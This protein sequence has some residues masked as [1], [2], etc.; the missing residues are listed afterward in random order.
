M[1]NNKLIGFTLIMLLIVVYYSYFSP[2]QAPIIEDEITETEKITNEK[3]TISN[4]TNEILN[5]NYSS[6]NNNKEETITIENENLVIDFNS[7]GAKILNVFLKKFKNTEGNQVK[8]YGHKE[9]NINYQLTSKN[10][11]DLDK[12]IFKHSTRKSD[13][14]IRITFKAISNDS[15]TIT[16]SYLLKNNSYLVENDISYNDNSSSNKTLKINWLNKI[17]HQEK[18]I[19]NEKLQ[20]TINY[21]Y[22]SEDFD[23]LSASS[24]ENQNISV[25]ESLLWITSKQQFFTSGIIN[26]TGF[27]NSDL[28]SIYLEDSSFVKSLNI[29]TEIS[30]INEG[31]SFQYFFGPN[32]YSLMKDID[33]DFY[34][35]INL[36]WIG[37]NFFNKNIIIPIFN[38]LET[39]TTNYGLIIFLMVLLIRLIIT[40]LTYKS[41]ISMAKL[42]VLNP[43]I[44]KIKDKHDGDMQKS[45]AEIMELYQKTGVSPLGGCL[46]LLFQLPILVSIFYFIPNSVELRGKSFL[47]AQDLSNYDSIL[48][49]PF[50]IPFYGDHISLFTLLMTVSTLLINQA[51]SQMQTIEGPMKTVQYVFPF[52][53][54]FIFNNFSSGL[55]YYY[56]LSNVASYAQIIIFKRFVDDEK[57]K[58]EIEINRK[59][60]INKKKSS[61]QLRLEEAMK[62]KQ[63]SKKKNN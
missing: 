54:L 53:F 4:N 6:N 21:Y 35:N 59:K 3:V 16:I 44:K 2:N 60:T 63:E 19:S 49:L 22:K 50:T 34:Q 5:E 40:P 15:N 52:M 12:I 41:H 11:I 24:K 25:N 8:I 33:N 39:L 45:Q 14:E 18:N 55:T 42:K 36:G 57:L 28:E 27:V 26:E 56:F 51:N 9:S 62:A 7:K 30:M 23:Y 13:E 10:K 17:H 47:W 58:K 1:D 29:N 48:N 37:V 38:F 61:F 46:P 20:T 32:K 43:E 31:I